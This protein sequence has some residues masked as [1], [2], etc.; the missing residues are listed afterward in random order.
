VRRRTSSGARPVLVGEVLV[1]LVLVFVYDRVR[2][3]A[4][5]RAGEAVSNARGL[6]SVE[7]WLHVDAERTLNAA[8]AQHHGTELAVSWYYQTMHLSVTLLVLLWVYWRRAGLYRTARRA[9][10]AV[11]VIALMVFWAFPVAPPRLV[12]GSGF[13][14]S[15]VVTGVAARSTTVTPDVFAAMPSL[16]VAWA[17]WV[18][19]QVLAG[20]RLRWA[21][22][23][24]VA[25][26][27]FTCIFVLATAN[28]FLLDVLAGAGLALLAQWGVRRTPGTA[29]SF[30]HGEPA[31]G[32]GRRPD[33]E[34]A[35]V[36][37]AR[38]R[39]PRD[40]GAQG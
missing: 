37:L 25:H 2:D 5:T 39:A 10:V 30:G 1:V 6:L 27:S 28:H 16:H 34:A 21:R 23:L 38:Q 12:P 22:G 33:R 7:R 40:V 20:T 32:G 11:N 19:L 29:V 9:L 4:A 31:R 36:R 17:T 24:A 14:D 15:A 26:L 35:G 8:L 18:V 3:V 13:V